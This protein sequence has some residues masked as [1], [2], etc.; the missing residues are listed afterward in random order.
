MNTALPP[1]SIAINTIEIVKQC[2]LAEISGTPSSNSFVLVTQ[3]ASLLLLGQYNHARHLWRRYRSEMI[4][5][6]EMQ[7]ATNHNNMEMVQFQMLWN[8]AQPL[9]RSFYGHQSLLDCG[10]NVFA[11]LQSCVNAN[12]HPVSLYSNELIGAIRNQM[13]EL[14]ETVYDSIQVQKCNMLLGKSNGEDIDQYLLQRGWEKNAELWI[15]ANTPDLGKKDFDKSCSKGSDE[16]S[17][18]DF[19]SNVVGFME[20]KRVH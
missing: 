4:S 8:A 18:I 20:N 14:V 19:L 12:L 7:E 5:D 2:E 9:L 3:L 1:N 15:P 10:T 11:S 13:A 6:K 16:K 17:K